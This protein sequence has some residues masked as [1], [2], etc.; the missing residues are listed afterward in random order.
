MQV[1]HRDPDDVEILALAIELGHPFWT[2]DKDFEETGVQVFT[3]AE[4]L[5]MYFPKP[6]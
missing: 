2:N 5:T 3:T 6:S 4:L 1:A